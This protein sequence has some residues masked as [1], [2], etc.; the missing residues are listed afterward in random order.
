LEREGYALNVV[1][2]EVQILEGGIEVSSLP[3]DTEEGVCLCDAIASQIKLGQRS[4]GLKEEENEKGCKS[5]E[6]AKTKNWS[7]LSG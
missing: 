4:V 6:T 1:A 2:G 3:K 7:V 5:D